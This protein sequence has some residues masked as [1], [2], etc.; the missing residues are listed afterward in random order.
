[1]RVHSF[2]DLFEPLWLVCLF[3]FAGLWGA[4]EAGTLLRRKL[5]RSAHVRTGESRDS[6]VIS[7]VLGLLGLLVAFTFSLAIDRFDA[8]RLLVVTEANALGT[9]WLRTD[10][11][12]DPRRVR[13]LLVAYTEARL[14]YGRARAVDKPQHLARAARLRA[15]LW[16]E[17]IGAVAPYRTT[18][19]AP[20]M[21]APLNEAIDT[22]SA[23]EAALAARLPTS[24]LNMLWVYALLAA[25][26]LGFSVP[27][28][29][30]RLI[31][32]ALFALL[33]LAL[34][35]IVDLDR[36][37]SGMVQV[38]Q[39]PLADTLQMMRDAPA[40]AAAVTQIGRSGPTP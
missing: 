23:R 1:M 35:L 20:L 29:Q 19:L 8:R 14:A 37:R 22:A 28:R 18:P 33:T 24:V 26:T 30:Y 40:P 16:R 27:G 3:A 15:S 5:A 13:P 10:L 39:R 12:D 2:I 7:G 6:Y 9:T 17:T 11:L 31:S 36:P 34:A 25:A 32:V 38:S 21:L 4:R